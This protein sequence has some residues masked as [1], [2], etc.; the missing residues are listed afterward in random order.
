[1]PR[2]TNRQSEGVKLWA[3][4][5]TSLFTLSLILCSLTLSRLSD[6]VWSLMI[7]SMKYASVRLGRTPLQLSHELVGNPL[8]R[9]RLVFQF[10]FISVSGRRGMV[11]G[12]A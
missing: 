5:N 1:M 3:Q 9:Q 6:R 7:E 8:H 12:Q 10:L 4:P 2:Q 11:V